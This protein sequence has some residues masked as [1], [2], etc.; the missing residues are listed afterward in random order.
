[1]SDF[2]RIVTIGMCG[3]TSIISRQEYPFTSVVI[4]VFALHIAFKLLVE[5]KER[6]GK[7]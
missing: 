6:M 4:A 3:L 5:I 7:K 2:E 1:M